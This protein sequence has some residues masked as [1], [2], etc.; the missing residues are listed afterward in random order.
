MSVAV[1]AVP[2]TTAFHSTA[3][4]SSV[5]VQLDQITFDIA[6]NTLSGLIW[7]NNVAFE[8]SV[9]VGYST[10]SGTFGNSLVIAASYSSTAATPFESWSFSLSAPSL[11]VGSQLYISYTVNGKTYFDNNETTASH[12][13][14]SPTSIHPEGPFGHQVLLQ[15][16]TFDPTTSSFSGTIFVQKLASQSVS[17][18]YSNASGIFAS[19]APTI[20]ASFVS[21][22]SSSHDI[23]S[24][25]SIIPATAGGA[26]SQFYIMYNAGTQ[27]YYD[28]NANIGD[29]LNYRIWPS[30]VVQNGWKGRAIYQAMTDR[31]ALPG[32]SLKPCT[33]SIPG[34]LDYCGGTWRG[35][36]DRL[37][38]LHNMGFDA[39]LISPINNQVDK[40]YHG[41]WPHDFG[42]LNS[43]FGTKED[44][45]ALVDACH[46][47]NMYI[48]IDMVINHVGPIANSPSGY[49]PE[50]NQ[51]SDFHS[52]F[53]CVIDY[54]GP[55]NQSEYENCRINGVNPD[56]NTENPGVINYLNAYGSWVYNTFKPDGLRMDAARHVRK[57]FY[58]Q[59]LNGAGNLFTVGEVAHSDTHYVAQYQNDGVPVLP[60]VFDY[61]SFYSIVRN[62]IAYQHSFQGV[63]TS[64]FSTPP[65]ETQLSWNKGNFSD[66][67]LLIN[68]V[69]NQDQDRFLGVAHG[70]DVALLKNALVWVSFTSGMPVVYQGTEQLFKDVESYRRPL[71]DSAYAT[72]GNL[73]GWLSTLL[74]ARNVYGGNALATSAHVPRYTVS[75]FHVFQRGPFVVGVTNGGSGSGTITTPSMMVG[76]DFAGVTLRNVLNPYDVVVPDATGHATLTFSGGQPKV[77]AAF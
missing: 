57:D 65:L 54:S 58:P 20:H 62:L 17:V 28:S 52:P 6:T 2:V 29:T 51:L 14:P 37:D 33:Q 24:F 36:I 7:V 67:N 48:M 77:Y 76:M 43:H 64:S 55:L 16:Y 66:P 3:P 42:T 45:L 71:W 31:F 18:V 73:Y 46:T 49:P 11:G 60:S 59:F 9:F 34:L 1:S 63:T 72:T 61:P 5:M 21:P 19:P 15:S 68:F 44:L 70:N 50:I 12:P 13:A 10:P 69:D 27:T 32:M 74:V 40:G 22:Y 41:Y 26:G 47:R 53:N 30:R 56:L 25:S 39:I 8:K 4:S 35:M 23:W 75:N 38:Y